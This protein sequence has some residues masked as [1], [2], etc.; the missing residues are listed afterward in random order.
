MLAEGYVVMAMSGAKYLDLE[1]RV[2]TLVWDQF[3]MGCIQIFPV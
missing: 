3:K 1:G 2:I